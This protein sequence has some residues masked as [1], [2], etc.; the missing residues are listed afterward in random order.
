MS[1]FDRKTRRGRHRERRCYWHSARAIDTCRPT[2]IA[3]T[4]TFVIIPS[5]VD[6]IIIVW[7]ITMSRFDR[8]TGRG[9]HRGQRCHW[10]SARAIYTCRPTLIA[11]TIT[12]V[13]IPS[14][15]GTII[16]VRCSR[17]AI[18]GRARG[19]SVVRLWVGFEMGQ[20]VI[21]ARVGLTEGLEEGAFEVPKNPSMIGALV[22]KAGSSISVG[23][24]VGFAFANF[25][26]LDQKLGE[27]DF[28]L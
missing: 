13:I 10:R 16:I 11:A 15:I 21:C 26:A 4:I 23:L 27:L 6:T 14:P 25:E 20:D 7:F 18:S 1:R 5:P 3:V 17:T 12:F 8:R 9:R 2:W 22:G 19:C 28:E 24:C